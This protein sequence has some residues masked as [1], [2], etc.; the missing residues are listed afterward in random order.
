MKNINETSKNIYQP[1][2]EPLLDTWR[3]K[4][5]AADWCISPP[6]NLSNTSVKDRNTW[7]AEAMMSTIEAF[8]SLARV[9]RISFSP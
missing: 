8:S 1:C 9:F 3:A 2:V 6:D 5:D 4:K 7:C